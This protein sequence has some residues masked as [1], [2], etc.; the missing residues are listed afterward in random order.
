MARTAC[1]RKARPKTPKLNVT[2]GVASC[3]KHIRFG[4][5]CSHCSRKFHAKC[6]SLTLSELKKHNN[7][8]DSIWFCTECTT[9]PLVRCIA[10]LAQKCDKLAQIVEQAAAARFVRSEP[11][12]ESVPRTRS[13][14]SNSSFGQ[15][16]HTQRKRKDL[17]LA[18][19]ILAATPNDTYITHASSEPCDTSDTKGG[20]TTFASIVTNNLVEAPSIMAPPT[21]K[22]GAVSTTNAATEAKTTAVAQ[23][24]KAP[25]HSSK[26][27][28]IR[29][30]HNSLT[31]ICSGVPESEANSI[32]EKMLDDRKQ[33]DS[34]CQL[35]NV[36]IKPASMTRLIR[37]PNSVHYGEPRL[38]QVTLHSGNDAEAVLLSATLL[39]T[40]SCTVR[41]FPD[42][43]WTERQKRKHKPEDFRKQKDVQSILV[44]GVPELL[45]SNE[46]EAR[47]HDWDEWRFIREVLSL[48]NVIAIS[49]SRLPSSPNYKGRGPRVLK[50][51]LQSKLMAV[52]TLEMWHRMRRY[53]PSEIRIK[54]MIT[55]PR[56]EKLRLNNQG[57]CAPTSPCDYEPGPSQICPPAEAIDSEKCICQ[58][59][60]T[61]EPLSAVQQKNQ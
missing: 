36:Q 47:A 24:K 57:T 37:H 30:Q 58:S 38:L 53:L 51:I 21:A 11:E 2:C 5:E 35:I 3:A 43:P 4:I 39:R 45:S 33:W 56:T 60:T 28:N 9:I 13:P 1:P 48:D 25:V 16:K 46:P 59:E 10:V 41:I 29:Q 31:V 14:T 6:A 27:E 52:R 15:S 26:K 23:P 49:T 22:I 42:V 17:G 61:P 20:L 18:T 7:A 55:Q 19:P 50:V 54:S 8:T 32:K 44:H 12:K 34:L 40:T